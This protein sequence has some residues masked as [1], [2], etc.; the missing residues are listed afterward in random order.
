MFVVFLQLVALLYPLLLLLTHHFLGFLEVI[1]L[2]LTRQI[3]S[4]LQFDLLR[5]YKEQLIEVDV[6]LLVFRLIDGN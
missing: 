4:G 5:L 6:L 1:P 3:S 2:S